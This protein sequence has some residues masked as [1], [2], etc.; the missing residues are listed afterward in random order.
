LSVE[1][2][3][4]AGTSV[5]GSSGTGCSSPCAAGS[6]GGTERAKLEWRLVARDVERGTLR[7]ISFIIA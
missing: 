3:G 1:N 7:F 2:D 6:V 4:V 5:G